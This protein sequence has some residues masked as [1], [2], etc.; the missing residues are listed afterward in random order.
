[1][2]KGDGLIAKQPTMVILKDSTDPFQVFK[3][4]G[5]SKEGVGLKLVNTLVHKMAHADLR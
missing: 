2:K 4:L 5:F 3:D 1:M